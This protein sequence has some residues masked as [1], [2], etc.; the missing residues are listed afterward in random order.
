MWQ[1]LCPRRVPSQK[2]AVRYWPL[3][4]AL[5]NSSGLEKRKNFKPFSEQVERR[6]IAKMF[7]SFQTISDD[8]FNPPRALEFNQSNIATKTEKYQIIQT[9]AFRMGAKKDPKSPSP[10]TSF[11]LVISTIVVIH[12]LTIFH[13]GVKFQGH[14][15]CQSQIIKLEPTALLKKMFFLVKSL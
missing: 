9:M 1:K 7:G 15:Q 11:S 14:A 4:A 13:T 3:V 10:P 2:F 8:D 12:P 6:H 5:F